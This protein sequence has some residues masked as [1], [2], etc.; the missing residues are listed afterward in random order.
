MSFFLWLE[1]LDE[2]RKRFGELRERRA[3]KL[4][5]RSA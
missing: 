1:D 3:E 4:S 5:E 2:N